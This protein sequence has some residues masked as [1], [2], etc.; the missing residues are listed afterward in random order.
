VSFR[1]RSAAVLAAGAVLAGTVTPVAAAEPALDWKPCPGQADA[2]CATLSLP[3]DWDHPGGERFGLAVARRTAS[4][5]AARVGSLVFGPGGPGD[6]GVERIRTGIDRF[7]DELRRR[8]DIVS[9]DPRG[10]GGSNPLVCS[11]S[12]LGRMPPLLIRNAAEFDAMRRYNDALRADCRERT[13]PLYDHLSARDTARDLEALR[14]ALGEP[15]LTFHGSSYGTLLGQ[16]YAELYPGRIRSMVLESV[17]DH[18]LS[19]RRFLDT[20]ALNAQDSFDQ[21]VAWCNRAARC[22]LHGRDV[23]AVL[24]RLLDRSEAGTLADPDRPGRLL[25][26]YD[27]AFFETQKRL[28]NP[29]PGWSE[30]AGRLARLDTAAPAASTRAAGPAPAV[31]PFPLPILCHDWNLGPRSY[32]EYAGHVRRAARLAPDLRYPGALVAPTICLGAPPAANPQ[33][34]LE[35]TGS[36]VILLANSRHDP[37]TGYDWARGVAR[38]LGRQGVLLTYQ[39]SGHGPYTK[40]PCAEAIVDRYLIDRVV[41]ARGTN[42]PSNDPVD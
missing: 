20:S 17:D 3:V 34:R 37:A 39:G 33:H 1:S 32:G 19:G 10:V 42:C 9:F 29:D 38:Q 40:S 2:E 18:S 25:A 27:L 7:S 15:R 36:P 35:V 11:T 41:P 26:P 13:G 21:F 14:A 5:P 23:R 31:A 30:L 16:Q 22:A 4:D 28:Y 8:F 24:G 12:V 6:S